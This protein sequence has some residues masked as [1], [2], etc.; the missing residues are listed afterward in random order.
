MIPISLP[1]T[2]VVARVPDGISRT[3]KDL[4]REAGIACRVTGPSTRRKINLRYASVAKACR[5]PGLSG[6]VT[7]D[8]PETDPHKRAL[9]ALG[10]LAYSAFDYAARES[11][12]GLPE[13]RPSAPRGRPRKTLPLTGAE[14]QRAWRERHSQRTTRTTRTGG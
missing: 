10:V 7:L 11:L 6:T 13:S 9:L 1:P 12:R 2:S 14:R 4:C 3:V 8:L 5:E